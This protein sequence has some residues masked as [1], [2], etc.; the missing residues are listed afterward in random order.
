MIRALLPAAMLAACWPAAAAGVSSADVLEIRAAIQRQARCFPPRPGTF[1]FRGVLV[2][3]E[4]V[5]QPVRI[6]DR[7]GGAWIAYYAMQR[8]Q[9]GSWKTHG[10]RLVQPRTFSA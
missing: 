3:G 4:E 6:T 8:Q 1:A 10:C 7:A 9:D 2:M 5:V